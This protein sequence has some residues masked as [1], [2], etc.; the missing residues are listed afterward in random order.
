MFP[1]RLQ[2]F[3]EINTN[4][5]YSNCCKRFAMCPNRKWGGGCTDDVTLA[6]VGLCSDAANV[7]K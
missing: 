3:K 2:F 1:K 4:C 7:N 5:I 6:V